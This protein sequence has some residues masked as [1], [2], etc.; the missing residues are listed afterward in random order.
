MQT[1]ALS[2]CLDDLRLDVKAAMDRAR[3][4][5][6]R[7]IDVGA[8][9]GPISPGELSRTG[10]RHLLKHLSDLGLRLG[11]LRGPVGGPGY[12]DPA[13][14]EGRVERMKRVIDLAAGLGVPTVSTSLGLAAGDADRHFE[15][16]KEAMAALADQADRAGV[17]VAVETGGI[18]AAE[19]AR[20]LAEIN[21][22]FLASCCDAGAMLMQ[23]EDPHRIAETLPGR[24]RLVR[25]R[26]A[27]A[28]SGGEAGHEVAIGEG[29]LDPARLLAAL[30]E[31]AFQG[32]IILTR[33]AGT[34]PAADLA[35]ARAVFEQH[36][37]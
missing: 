4:L 31:A 16:L 24:I 22:P 36:L 25:A 1:L 27:V 33:S 7:A 3:S 9:A 34:D 15:R 6:F 30:N 18:G 26:D 19:L 32:D 17:I 10:R 13:A 12:A 2:V 8:S 21:C 11:S 35:R 20:L 5:G 29:S 37:K 28:S 23:G 14:G